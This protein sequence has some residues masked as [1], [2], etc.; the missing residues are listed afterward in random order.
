[1]NSLKK[2]LPLDEIITAM[3]TFHEIRHILQKEGRTDIFNSFCSVRLS[4]YDSIKPYLSSKHHDSLFAEIDAHCYEAC[5]AKEY[6]KGNK[7]IEEYLNQIFGLYLLQMVYYDFEAEFE[8][9]QQE[10][11]QQGQ[12]E[13]YYAYEDIF[14]NSNGTFKRPKDI[15]N[16]EYR[17]NFLHE[18]QSFNELYIKI[19]SSNTYLSRID[20]DSL[21]MTEKEFFNNILQGHKALL[22]DDKCLLYN[23]YKEEIITEQGCL[24]ALNALN[25]QIE[26]KENIRKQTIKGTYLENTISVSESNEIREFIEK[27]T[28]KEEVKKVT[29]IKT[30]TER[31]KKI[32]NAHEKISIGGATICALAASLITTVSTGELFPGIIPGVS[33]NLIE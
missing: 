27:M 21:D 26:E 33:K 9:Y 7:D 22:E 10:T 14:W 16:N 12:F 3:T 19:L 8:K 15:L 20:V 29:T 31:I 1:M 2:K 4:K 17:K 18:K 30:A 6:F 24:F 25:K 28:E 32:V 5:Q 13:P 23:Y 11:E